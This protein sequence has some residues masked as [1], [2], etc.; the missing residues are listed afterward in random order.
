MALN[1]KNSK[2]VR[3]TVPNDDTE[4]LEWLSNQHA[5]SVS[6]RELIHDMI[7]EHGTQDYFVATRGE[8]RKA[9]KGRPM[10]PLVTTDP[11]MIETSEKIKDAP[12]KQEFVQPEVVSEEKPS[13]QDQDARNRILAMQGLLNK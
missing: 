7:A 2:R 10:K 6:V 5:M 4:V 13:V 9:G 3:V 8:A 1:E 11:T 12:V